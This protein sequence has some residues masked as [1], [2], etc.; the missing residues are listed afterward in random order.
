MLS[1][2]EQKS[3]TASKEEEILAFWEENNIFQKTLSKKS[4]E[5]EFVFYDGPPFAT[6][7]PH[8]GH[9]A[10]GIMKDVIPRYK[11]MLGFHVPRRW[12]WDCHGL[13][14]ENEV[15]KELG[16]KNRKEIEKLGIDVFN[17]RAREAVLRYADDWREIIPRTGRWIDMERD[18]RTM[19]WTYTESIWWVF[20]TLFDKKFIY[21][22]FK[23]MHICPR[24]ETTLSN[25]E[26]SQGYADITDLSVTVKL[27]LKDEP[28]TSLLVW[29]T[30]AWTLPGNMAVAVNPSIVYSKFKIQDPKLEGQYFIVAK[31]RAKQVF[32]NQEYE[33]IEEF[34]GDKLIG[35]AYEPPFDYFKD[36]QLI[37]KENAWKVYGARFVSL[38]EG[39]GIVHIAPAFGEDDL[40]LA[41]KHKLPIVHHVRND[42]T[43]SEEVAGFAGMP[44][45]PKENPQAGDVSILKNLVARDSIF[46]KEKI[47][48]S[49][50][51]CWR[52]D[53]PLL[54]YSA[55][56]WFVNVRK[57]R[58]KLISANQK[59]RWMP[60]ELRDGRFGKWLEGVR[61]WA[62]SRSRFWGAPLPVWKCASCSN[63]STIGSLDELK[64][65]SARSGNT[66]FLMRH[67]HAQNNEQNLAISATN[68]P[69]GLTQKGIREV[70]AAARK[71]LREDIDLVFVS[72][73]VRAQESAEVVAADLG[74]KPEQVIVDKRL[75]EIETGTLEGKV[76]DDYRAYFGS[77]E[78]KFVKAP[79]D[80]ENLLEVKDRVMEFFYEVE[81]KYSGKR[82]LVISHSDPLWMIFVGALGGGPQEALK[83]RGNRRKILKTGEIAEYVFVPLPH[84]EHYELDLHRPYIDGIVLA[85][86]C[87]KA[88]KRIPDVFDC[89]F[90]S[91]SMPYGQ[92]HYPFSFISP[93]SFTKKF[94]PADF[95]AEGIDQTRGWFYS[96]L[97]LSVALF[98]VSAYKSV[99]TN[100]LLLA[101]DGK[102]M[103]KRLKNYPDPVYIMNRYGA[104]ALRLYLLS[105]PVVRGENL[106]FSEHGVKEMQHK[107]VNRLRNVLAF[108]QTYTDDNPKTTL[109]QG[110][111]GSS[112][113]LDTWILLRLAELINKTSLFLERHELDRA[114]RPV[115][116]FIDDFSTWY[117]RRS[118]SR[119]KSEDIRDRN[120]AI[121]TTRFV[122]LEL[123]K[124]MAP[125]APFVAE[126][127]YRTVGGDRESVHLEEWPRRESRIP[128]WP[129]VMALVHRLLGSH[130]DLRI[131][132]DMD[133]V[134]EI[135]RSALEKRKEAGIKVRQPLA[136]LKVRKRKERI[137]R[138]QGLLQ[139][140]KDEV[141]VKRIHFG[142]SIEDDVWIDTKITPVLRKEG[143]LRE[144]VRFAQDLRKKEG[145]SPKEKAVLVLETDENGV[146][147]F[148]EFKEELQKAVSL[149]TIVFEDASSGEEA[150]I[151]DIRFK[152]ALKK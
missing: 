5:G 76:M 87:G 147:F 119:F 25:F 51:L 66:Y 150:S 128:V 100:G 142:A 111:G 102:K 152:A 53:T 37:N 113:V 92:F 110:V 71:L 81:K 126:E 96:L 95:I 70:R 64:K 55:M 97:V 106:N 40:L 24:C 115:L 46:A 114:T 20:K 90:E 141:N 63:V 19:D 117:L 72:P 135:V 15:E 31:E 45:K 10:A 61:D 68:A 104:D 107:A 57:L 41:R 26:V 108:Y 11:T 60:P 49:Y 29:T 8:Y 65:R 17:K 144:F 13:P 151:G 58:D 143:H 137:A 7:L 129:N 77:L 4:P 82:I 27:P 59:V 14:V 116:L 94:F 69:Y 109:N 105:S 50:P 93:D 6:G 43:F 3:D 138:N 79:P 136:E 21:E 48:H 124:V 120:A 75:R 85:C 84:N 130:E 121:A 80:G 9:I 35:K 132:S 131:L 56:S 47:T 18:Y 42:G 123:S 88:M 127:M 98:D 54:N 139:L 1:E 2:E 133:R 67:G 12:G 101:E 146:K 23:A 134:R 86:S 99:I 32:K 91:G 145:L 148:E 30:T 36:A 28:D 125:L 38:E 39:T 122:I 52:C 103:S 112:H 83:L 34:K 44:A 118:R 16:L 73:L 74:L 78:N 33:L 22:G 140:I 62:V 89:W 149:R